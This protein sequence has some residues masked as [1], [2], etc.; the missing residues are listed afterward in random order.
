MTQGKSNEIIDC[1]NAGRIVITRRSKTV[2]VPVGVNRGREYEV[3]GRS[4]KA[5]LA[6]WFEAAG[7]LGR[8]SLDPFD[9]LKNGMDCGRKLSRPQF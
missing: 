6:L 2:W 9:K 3:K 5:A 7:Y 1:D 8:G 4:P